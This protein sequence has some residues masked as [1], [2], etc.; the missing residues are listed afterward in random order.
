MLEKSGQIYEGS[1]SDLTIELVLTMVN[2]V[3]KSGPNPIG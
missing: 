1:I 2:F 3:T